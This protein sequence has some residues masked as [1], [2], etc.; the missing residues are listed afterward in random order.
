MP[1]SP[2]I[3]LAID[4]AVAESQTLEVPGLEEEKRRELFSTVPST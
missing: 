3:Y 2:L 1:P 4:G